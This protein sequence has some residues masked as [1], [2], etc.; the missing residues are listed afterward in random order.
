MTA[1]SVVQDASLYLGITKPTQVFGASGRNELEL[2]EMLNEAAQQIFKAHDWQ[3]LTTIV[4]GADIPTGDGSTEDF[5]LPSD[6]DRMD[7]STE[8]W[9]SSLETPLAH[10]VDRNVW[11][12]IDI[13]SFDIVINAWTL[14]GDQ[15]HIKPALG[16]GVTAKYWYVSN[17]I[18]DPATGD[19]KAAF[20]TD[21]DVF[22]LD[23]RALKLGLIWNWKKSKGLSYQEEMNEYNFLMQDL[24][25]RDKGSR[26]I[27]IGKPRIS[28]GARVAYPQT[29]TP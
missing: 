5:A 24:I 1:L 11:L 27:R 16:T 9:S 18:V 15:I 10:I 3:L 21:T 26:T 17:L 25:S 22:R 12:G 13:R 19:N 14:Y 2:A 6:Y 23:E 28:S 20:D 4:A 29:I 8:V 7:D